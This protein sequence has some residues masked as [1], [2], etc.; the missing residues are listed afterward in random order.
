MSSPS[1][2][3]RAPA[4]RVH[5][6][7]ARYG[8][9]RASVA[10]LL[11]DQHPV[12]A[13]AY[14]VV[15]PDLSSAVLTYG[16]LRDKSERFAAAL[17]G[18][19]V[20]PG[21]R[22]ATLM[23]KSAEYLVALLGIWRLGAIHVPLFT[24][25]APPAIVTRLLGSEARVVICDDTQHGK[26]APGPEIPADPPWRVVVARSGP[27]AGQAGDP[28]FARLLA[29][30]EPGFPAAALGGDAPIVH[31]YTSGTTGVPKG[32]I[33]PT[34]AIAGFRAYLEFGLDVRS[35]DV[36]WC[37]A[38]PGWAYGLYFGVIG[39]FSLGVPSVFLQAGFSPELTWAVLRKEQVT[40]FAAA[41]TVYRALRAAEIPAPAGLPLR[42]AS[43]AGEPLTPD[44]NQWAEQALGLPVH[45][46][47]GQTEAGM[48][49]NNHHHPALRRPLKPGSMGQAMPGWAVRVL[50][51]DRDELA[52]AGTRGRIAVDTTTSPLAWFHGYAG[53]PA[54]SAEKFT[55]D[56]R[57]YL[58]GDIG[59][60]D[61][62]GYV[63]FS[64][65][66]D[67][68]IIM[69]GYRIGPFEVESVLA[70]HPDVVE[71]AVIAVPDRVRGE[72]LEA[73]VVLA[74]GRDGSP[75]LEAELQQL[76]RAQFAAH[77]YPRAVHF[78]G[79]LPKTPSGK[80]QRFVL[81]QRR[82]QELEGSGR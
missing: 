82:R 8:D 41:P 66:D 4:D 17:A 72:I 38:D 81:R 3:V 31:I 46:H 74:G 20:A 18:L 47:Y 15:Q 21:D 36:Y 53:N 71:C 44:V 24:A 49:V 57:W 70:T 27:D 43:S 10:A 40:N 13:V 54:K 56:G 28:D 75:E 79:Q 65:R 30:H 16:Q 9:P 33:V 76:V 23:G 77:A 63:H 6:L 55:A 45:D 78:T 50:C 80:I 2:A 59:T 12:D 19:G 48:L 22:V 51:A 39:S 52:P 32:V 35:G 37:A 5:D 11:C 73:Y 64:S 29:E 1:D 69:A 60:V 25:F 14:T 34:V 67:D 62:D 7:L 61:D 58:T 68:V 42:C 26:L